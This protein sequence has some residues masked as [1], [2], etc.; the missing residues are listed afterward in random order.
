[1]TDR[2]AQARTAI[3]GVPGWLSDD[4]AQ[5]LWDRA[6]ALAPGATIVE[7]GSFRGR[8]TIVLGLA[9]PPGATVFAIDPHAGSDRG[10]QEIAADADRGDADHAAFTANLRAARVQER[11]RHL[12]LPS[13]D[14]LAAIPGEID[15]LYVDGA[16]RYRPALADIGTYGERVAPGGSM[17]VHDAFSS[18]GVTL[19]ILTRLVGAPDFAYAGRSRSLAEYRRARGR[20]AAGARLAGA[21][22]QLA[23]LPWFARNLAIKLALVARSPAVAQ[24]LGHRP[25]DQ[26]PY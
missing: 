14:A 13:A 3:D 6:A 26:W 10:P 15:L 1:M 20:L 7:I 19:A 12:R 4:Q 24:R 17:L 23:Q 22:E 2:F 5:R 16:H 21:G 9:A 11:V 18:I 8:S 25:G